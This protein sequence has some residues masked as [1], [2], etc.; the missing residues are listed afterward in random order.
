[1]FPATQVPCSAVT[2]A[3]SNMFHISIPVQHS[4]TT[5]HHST[6]GPAHHSTPQHT[7]NSTPRHTAAHQELTQAQQRRCI[8]CIQCQCCLISCLSSNIIPAG[9]CHCTH[10]LV[11]GCT[12]WLQMLHILY[13][14]LSI[15]WLLLTGVCQCKVPPHLQDDQEHTC[16]NL[17]CL[18]SARAGHA[19]PKGGICSLVPA[20]PQATSCT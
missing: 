17:D 16:Q 20:A 12:V 19:M 2:H 6:P 18:R 1:M 11:A 14:F 7:R 4:T 5:A 3:G 13:A 8:G 10:C 15:L 9:C